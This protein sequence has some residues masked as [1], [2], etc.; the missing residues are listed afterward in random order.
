MLE[1]EVLRGYLGL[2]ELVPGDDAVTVDPVRCKEVP[3]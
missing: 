2:F 3:M 1:E